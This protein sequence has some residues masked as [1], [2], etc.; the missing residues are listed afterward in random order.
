[1]N[2][3]KKITYLGMGI[4]LYVVL[5]MTVKIPLINQIK[6]DFGYLAFGAFLNLFGMEGTLVGVLGCII[7]NSFVGSAF[8]PGWVAGQ[9]FIGLFCGYLLKK[10]DKLW[11]KALICVAGV[12]IGIAV[13]KTVIEVALF[14]IPF[15]IKII[16][17]LVAFVADSIPMVLGVIISDKMKIN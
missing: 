12:F 5:S 1:M 8:P 15:N 9:L 4:A 6:T 10:T 14:A 2:R 7:A 13:I 16:R 11:L 17:N 3:T